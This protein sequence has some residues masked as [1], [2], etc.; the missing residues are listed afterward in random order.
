MT[1][2]LPGGGEEARTVSPRARAV[3]TVQAWKKQD[4]PVA[5]SSPARESIAQRLS[6]A[7]EGIRTGPGGFR[8]ALAYADSGA[9]PAPVPNPYGFEDLIDTINPLHHIPVVGMAYRELTGDTISGAAQIV[10]GALFG[11]P[12]GAVAGTANAIVQQRTGADIAGNVLSLGRFN[13]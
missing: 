1:T 2:I 11:G 7:N 10:G 9:K 3:H 4:H 8:A 5:S 13:G 6:N 12:V